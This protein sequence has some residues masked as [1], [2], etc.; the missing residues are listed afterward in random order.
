MENEYNQTEHAHIAIHRLQNTIFQM[1]AVHASDG[2]EED[3]HCIYCGT[4]FP[5]YTV[6]LARRAQTIWTRKKEG[7]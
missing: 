3:A 7:E 1:T 5:C 4:E 2:R 6:R